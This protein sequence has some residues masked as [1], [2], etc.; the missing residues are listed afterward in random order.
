ML[1]FSAVD[2]GHQIR[3]VKENLRSGFDDARFSGPGRSKK[4]QRPDRPTG[5]RQP[6]QIDL[7]KTCN[8]AKSA[9]LTDNQR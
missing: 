1:K 6:R 5:V 3:I 9:F 7:I 4:K 2:L 8:P